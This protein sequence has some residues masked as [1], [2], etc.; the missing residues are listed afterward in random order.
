MFPLSLDA[1]NEQ[2]ELPGL[3]AVTAPRKTARMRSQDLL[4]LMLELTT[5]AGGLASITA[6]QQQEILNRLAETYFATPGSVTA[7][8]RTVVTR[9]N[10]FLLNR[11]LRAAQGGQIIGSLNLAA[12]HG[13]ILT[14]AHGGPTHSY[15]LDKTHAQHF[16]DSLISRGLGLS[17][18]AVPRFYQTNLKA[19]D[20]LILCADPPAA[21]EQTFSGTPNL[22]LDHLR[23]RMLSDAGIQFRA[24]V[25]KFLAGKGQVNQWRP[26]VARRQRGDSPSTSTQ[27]AAVPHPAAGGQPIR[28]AIPAHP[29]IPQAEEILPVQGVAA[30]SD[31]V[32]SP[33][34]P[35]MMENEE[36]NAGVSA[37]EVN[38]SPQVTSLA[39]KPEVEP[40]AAENKEETLKMETAG[41]EGIR[42][43]RA[44]RMEERG[45]ASGSVGVRPAPR[46][47]VPGKTS[48]PRPQP[49]PP[50]RES[51]P[52]LS[53]VL[54]RRLVP[55][56]RKAISARG[57]ISGAVSRLLSRLFPKRSEPLISLSPST[58]L[59]IAVIVPFLIGTAGAVVYFRMGRSERFDL[60]MMQAKQYANQVSQLSDPVQQREGWGR[61]IEIL[62]EAEKY[63]SSEESA[64]LYRQ[65][66]NT[67][68]QLEGYVRLDFR[69]VTSGGFDQ[70][71]NI[72]RIL[73]RLNQVYLLDSSQGRILSMTRVTTGDYEINPFF[74]CGPGKAGGAFIGPLIDLAEL[75]VNNDLNAEVLGI[76]SAGNLVYC[77]SNKTGFDS[78]P[79]AMP[80]TGWGE[81]TGMTTYNDTLYVLDPKANAVYWYSGERGI[82]AG[83]PHLYFDQNIPRMADVVDLAVDQEFLYLLHADGRMT[84]CSSGGVSFATTRCTDPAPYGDS[85]AGYEPSPLAFPDTSFTQI[86]TTEPPDPSLFALDSRNTSI[87]HLSQRRMN[88]QRQYRP[89]LDSDFPLPNRAPTAFA[90]SPNRRALLAFGYEVFYA[91][92]P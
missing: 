14:L 39:G 76:D 40:A 20:V 45:Q 48:F 85:R 25:I 10:D 84:I 73:A 86:Q 57:R 42:L 46:A 54:R 75:P 63:G 58:M 61:V 64:E 83:P 67:L 41:S 79:L 90:I 55:V 11:N 5:P 65:A 50:Q 43:G 52:G 32:V 47:P 31:V 4:I 77:A 7:G 13:E 19:N 44:V 60:L 82:Y 78:R 27:T 1:G 9:L 16:D 72:T 21:W 15:F 30:G 35:E 62:E 69:P 3:L 66:V 23:R 59:I 26:A 56:W 2:Y 33:N 81:I 28:E 6:A 49:V 37:T 17:R 29:A 89:M 22:A 92:L 18:N 8:L 88:Y 70:S 87:Y 38:V 36:V 91:S 51:G 24:G 74:N 53:E 12:V 68:D 34:M 80:D 71:V